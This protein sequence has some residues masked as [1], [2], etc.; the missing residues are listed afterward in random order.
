MPRNRL[1]FRQRDISAVINAVE[2]TGNKVARIE[3]EQDGRIIVELA[4][5]VVD[6]TAPDPELN[7]RDE[8][9]RHASTD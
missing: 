9:L 7:P 6:G 2:R 8:V 3:I 1:T 5:P 4:L